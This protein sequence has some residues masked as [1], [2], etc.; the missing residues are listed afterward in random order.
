MSFAPAISDA[1][2]AGLLALA[3][4]TPA[5]PA[6][7]ADRIM[8]GVAA[9]PVPLPPPAAPRRPQRAWLRP[10]RSAVLAITASLALASAVAAGIA[11]P[12]LLQPLIAPVLERLGLAPRAPAPPPRAPRPA[13][14]TTAAAPPAAAIA[15]PAPTPAPVAAPPA[16]LPASLAAPPLPDLPRFTPPA[17]PAAA[18]L[19]P[20]LPATARPERAALAAA[21]RPARLPDIAPPGLPA[22]AAPVLPPPPVVAATGAP[23]AATGAPIAATPAPDAATN[24]AETSTLPLRPADLPATAADRAAALQALRQ[25]RQN[26]TLTPDQARQLRALQALRA[27]RAARPPREAGPRR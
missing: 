20:G 2:L 15:G 4:S 6:G 16:R 17:P 11:N 9:D 22:T 21:I 14:V 25:A 26:G 1:D 5:M 12:A 18:R 8:A 13:R 19:R 3:G 7:L 24:P 27:A 23:P 10:G